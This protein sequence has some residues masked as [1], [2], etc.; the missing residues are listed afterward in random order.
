MINKPTI[1][2]EEFNKKA[3]RGV[4][5]IIPHGFWVFPD[6]EYFAKF[7]KPFSITKLFWSIFRIKYETFGEK[8]F[9]NQGENNAK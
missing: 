1:T 7:S 5:S 9:K 6:G 3:I 8:P 4:R 2:Q